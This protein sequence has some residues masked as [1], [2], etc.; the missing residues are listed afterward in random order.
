MTRALNI[1]S[2]IIYL[3]KKAKKQL[4]IGKISSTKRLFKKIIKLEKKELIAIK[5][6]SGSQ[7]LFLKC[8]IIYQET[9][10]AF[11]D[12]KNLNIKDASKILDKIIALTKIEF[13]T[14]KNQQN[15]S[16]EILNT[17]DPYIRDLIS[18]INKLSFIKQTKFSCSGHF[19]GFSCPYLVIEYNWESKTKDNIE[20]FHQEMIKIVETSG[21]IQKHLNGG[22]LKKIYRLKGISKINYYLGET[23]LNSFFDEETIRKKLIKQWNLISRLVKK[24]QDNDSLIYQKQ[25]TYINKDPILLGKSKNFKDKI[26]SWFKSLT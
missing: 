18:E 13:S 24:F 7:E 20:L 9:K 21:I 1:I 12:F 2:Q 22:Y 23:G 17:V 25:K 6:E 5:K 10:K 8:Q 16:K 19:P 4:E 14:I 15:L 11:N 3:A 26:I